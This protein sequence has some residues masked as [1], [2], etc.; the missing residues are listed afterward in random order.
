MVGAWCPSAHN[1]CEWFTE[2]KKMQK[3]YWLQLQAPAGNYYDSL[4]LEPRTTLDEA[5]GR[6]KD[7][8]DFH[9]P[10]RARLI[11]R[12]DTPIDVAGG[13]T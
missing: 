1:G 4:G 6:F 3:Q 2:R 12:V 5:V 9:K 8:C 7:F 10:Q 11:E 13:K